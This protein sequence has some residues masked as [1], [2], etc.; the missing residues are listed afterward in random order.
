M[1]AIGLDRATAW[2]LVAK[3]GLDSI[4]KLRRSVFDALLAES[5]WRDTAAIAAVTKHPTITTRRS[6]EDL[7]AHGVVERQAGGEGEG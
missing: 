2:P 5:D 4:P 1:L 7:G 6:L 3:T